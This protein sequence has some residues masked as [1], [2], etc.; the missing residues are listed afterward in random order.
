MSSCNRAAPVV[1]RRLVLRPRANSQIN[2]WK[3]PTP[4]RCSE[5]TVAAVA[6][7]QGTAQCPGQD[8]IR[9]EWKVIMSLCAECQSPLCS[10]LVMCEGI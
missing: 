5:I 2:Q 8:A 6:H 4:P 9:S 10:V 3:H 7:S 1:W